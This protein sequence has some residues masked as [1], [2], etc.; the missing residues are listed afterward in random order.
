MEAVDRDGMAG[1]SG[2]RERMTGR[3]DWKNDVLPVAK[4]IVESY[5]TA[6]TLR[7][8]FYR[9]VSL[10]D[11]ERGRIP[12]THSMYTAL[13]Y[14]TAQARYAG[15]FPDLVDQRRSITQRGGYESPQSAI[16]S[17]CWS[18][19]RVRTE[20]QP[21]QIWLG[22]EKEGLVNQLYD[23]FGSDMGLPIAALIGQCSVPYR[24]KILRQV[25][26]DGRPAILL[27]AGDHD[28]TGWSILQNFVD[29]TD[30]W[31]NND[32]PGFD[33]S[34]M[35]MSLGRKQGHAR[36]WTDVPNFNRYRKFRVALTPEQ[37]DQYALAGNAATA[38][39]PSMNTFLANFEHTLTDD[40]VDDGLGVQ[41]EVDALEPTALRDLFTD[42]I[43]Q[44]W[45]T[46]A[47]DAVLSK[48][49]ADIK[50]LDGI[51]SKL[52]RRQR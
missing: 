17:I 27:Y 46:D 3:L 21:Y 26:A 15:E 4:A 13:A 19:H 35:P 39:D 10:K 9:L 29:R 23:W 41:V 5:D 32:L 51:V 50:V 34:H 18:Y 30:C 47:Y 1:Q 20:G 31:V 49:K 40:E 2:V 7:Q 25:R 48:E 38:A 42:A 11:G 6:V 22:S 16:R 37:C 24:D 28:P 43:E 8:L 36:K 33:S 44:Y 52:V 45:D 14:N 12:N